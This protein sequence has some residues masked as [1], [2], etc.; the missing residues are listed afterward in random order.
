VFEV[1]AQYPFEPPW[2][3]RDAAKLPFTGTRM[4]PTRIGHH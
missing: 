3:W 2:H 1:D 4:W